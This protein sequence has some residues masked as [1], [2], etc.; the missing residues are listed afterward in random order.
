VATAAHNDRTY[1]AR[2][3]V[4]IASA[5]SCFINATAKTCLTVK[6]SD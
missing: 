1:L 6:L 5:S 2:A 3:Q 4:C